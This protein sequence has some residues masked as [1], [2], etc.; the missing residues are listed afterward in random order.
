MSIHAAQLINAVPDIEKKRYLELGVET[1]ET[2]NV[3]RAY[4]KH[5]VDIAVRPAGLHLSCSVAYH[6]GG[7]DNFF[8]TA[9]RVWDVIFIDAG[10]AYEQVLR[11]YNNSVR[12]LASGGY[13]FIHDLVPPSEAHCAL[14]WCGDGW[15]LLMQLR[16]RKATMVTLDCDYGLT[17]VR[18]PPR[19]SV[20]MC[21]SFVDFLPPNGLSVDEM[22]DWIRS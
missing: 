8:E 5:G 10:H 12:H 3:V 4:Q 13:L 9:E 11:D 20:P 1:G 21:A 19:I 2:F 16:A 18:Y 14:N 22:I 7:T 17:C 15:K 6:Q